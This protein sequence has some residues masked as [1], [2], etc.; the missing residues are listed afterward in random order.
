MNLK[1]L[2]S[3]IDNGNNESAIEVT[4]DSKDHDGIRE[5]GKYFFVIGTVLQVVFKSS[6]VSNFM[7]KKKLV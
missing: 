2:F 7:Y 6:T 1:I 5:T 4:A 3:S